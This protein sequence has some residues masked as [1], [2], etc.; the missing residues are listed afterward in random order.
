[1]RVYYFTCTKWALDDLKN[2]WL[3]VCRF[4]ALNDPFELLASDMP[5]R[6]RRKQMKAWADDIDRRHGLLCFCERWHDPLMWSHYGDRHR[7][8]CL[9]FDVDDRILRT[10]TYSPQRLLLSQHANST[11]LPTAQDEYRLLTTKYERWTYERERRIIVPLAEAVRQ[12]DLYFR[13]FDQGLELAVVIAGPRCT[14]TMRA[15]KEALGGRSDD[16]E[17]FKARLAFRTF[18]VVKNLE[19]F[20]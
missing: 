17:I 12:S 8:M 10:I 6:A 19:G 11:H 3:K 16:T 5:N 2:K 15:V 14:T 18:R 9:G 7:G 20:H 13:K 1:M 4:S